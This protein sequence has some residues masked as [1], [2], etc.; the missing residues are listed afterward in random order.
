MRSRRQPSVS[1]LRHRLLLFAS[2][3]RIGLTSLMTQHALRLQSVSRG[4]LVTCVAGEHEQLPGLA[5]ALGEAGV[6]LHRIPG[7]D[8]HHNPIRLTRELSRLV[9]V[10]RPTIVHVQTNWQLALAV[11]ARV[12]PRHKAR[13]LYTVH[14]FRHNRPVLRHLARA[15]MLAGL[16]WG[17]DG[18]LAP[19]RYVRRQFASAAPLVRLWPLGVDDEYFDIGVRPLPANSEFRVAFAG[20]FRAGKGQELLVR[21]VAR[22]GAHLRRRQAKITLPGDGPLWSG[23]QEL[24]HRLGVGDLFEFPGRLPKSRMIECLSRSHAVVIPSNRETFGLSIAEAMA[25]GR[26]VLARPVGV[27]LDAIQHGK[28]GFMF[29]TARDLTN[30]LLA[31]AASDSLQEIARAAHACATRFRW[32]GVT[33]EYLKVLDELTSAPIP[34]A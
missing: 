25:A 26:V 33:Q 10:E 24:A 13:I 7:L 21:A 29:S 28:N 22:C 8:E 14:G 34:C 1:L 18:I 11:A 2:S 17:C 5:A 16:R 6:R 20:E 30:L 23:V 9:E 31:V 19:S 15:L 12:Q 4:L 3:H 27:A 32:G